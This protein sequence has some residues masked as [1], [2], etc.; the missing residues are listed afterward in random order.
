MLLRRSTIALTAATL[1][2]TLSA[3][4]VT[5]DPVGPQTT[6]AE[7][8]RGGGLAP[9]TLGYLTRAHPGSPCMAPSYRE[10]DF[11]VGAWDV[12]STGGAPIG[13]NLVRTR[14]DGCIV[15]ENWVSRGGGSGRSINTYDAET[16]LWGQTWVSANAAG[17]LRM[18]GGLDADGR[19][20]LEGKRV[21]TTGTEIFDRYEW[22]PLSGGRVRQDGFLDVPSIPVSGQFTGIYVPSDDFE[23]FP[24]APSASCQAG[25]FGAP[26]RLFDF[27][28]GSWSVEANGQPIASSE[29]I[30]DL[31]GCLFEEVFTTPKGYEAVAYTYY[32]AYEATWYRTYID[33]EGERIELQGGFDGDALVLTGTEA[34]RGASGQ[35]LLARV[36]WTPRADGSM[37]VAHGTSSDGGTTWHDELVLHY[38]P[39]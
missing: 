20:I 22:T 16:G 13:T 39:S 5:P 6:V 24:V 29:V 7:A 1:A 25:G 21:T 23:P 19:M 31:S 36:T 32:M 33:S 17:H 14:A 38:V 26:S 8:P 15:E 2:V 9:F 37:E 34:G 27:A 30:V 18:Y 3:C 4:D 35:E 11:W 28:A 12:E 10:F